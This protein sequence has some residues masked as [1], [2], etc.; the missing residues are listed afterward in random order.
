MM[1][2]MCPKLGTRGLG[3]SVGVKL[4]KA[5]AVGEG[6]TAVKVA[7]TEGT[8]DAM[9]GGA[10]VV[11]ANSNTSNN[12]PKAE[13]VIQILSSRLLSVEGDFRL[14]GSSLSRGTLLVYY[15]LDGHKT[16]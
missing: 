4:G 15:R 13:R 16:A 8:G 11:Q 9:L 5:V 7:V 10:E 3:V 6:G 1:M 14:Q 2:A 12:M